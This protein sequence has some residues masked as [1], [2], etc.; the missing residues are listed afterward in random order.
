MT[1]PLLVADASALVLAVTD[2]TERGRS[3]LDR[4]Q[5]HIVHAPHLVD[6]EVGSALRRLVRRGLLDTE[7]A[8]TSRRF[9]EAVVGERYSHEGP[10]GEWAWAHRDRVGFYDG[11]YAG[12]AALL[13]CTLVTADRRLARGVPESVSITT[14]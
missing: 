9:A 2:G 7:V 12:L 3:V 4:L 6:P 10:L 11:L 13:G 14:C 8:A 1:L 5:R